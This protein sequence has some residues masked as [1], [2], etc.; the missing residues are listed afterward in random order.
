[1]PQSA[2]I[3]ENE[4]V[5]DVKLCNLTQPATANLIKVFQEFLIDS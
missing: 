3:R 1:M 2:W 4:H 5:L